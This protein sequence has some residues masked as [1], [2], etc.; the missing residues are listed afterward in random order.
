MAG[1]LLF[2]E[3][4]VGDPVAPQHLLRVSWGIEVATTTYRH[5]RPFSDFGDIGSGLS[6]VCRS[7]ADATG[8]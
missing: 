1:G 3:Q 8:A 7:I 5:G 6:G 4:V 2:V